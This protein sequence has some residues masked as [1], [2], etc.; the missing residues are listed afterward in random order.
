MNRPPERP[1][2]GNKIVEA[3]EELQ[4]PGIEVKTVAAQPAVNVTDPQPTI[5]HVFLNKLGSGLP[6]EGFDALVELKKLLGE[7]GFQY[8]DLIEVTVD[9][10]RGRRALK[11]PGASEHAAASIRMEYQAKDGVAAAEEL[12]T[13][14]DMLTLEDLRPQGPPPAVDE[15]KEKFRGEALDT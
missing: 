9:E 5:R 15:F 11:A 6:Q 12:A 14:L 10:Y 4:I 7:A 8:I 1:N 3:F 2:P 13:Y